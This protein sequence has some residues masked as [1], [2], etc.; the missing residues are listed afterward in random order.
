MGLLRTLCTN[1]LYIKNS[2]AKKILDTFDYIGISIDGREEIHDKFRG[3]KGSFKE[4]LK[5]IKLLN[6]FDSKKI[7]IRFTLTKETYSSLEF[8]FELA[9]NLN[10]PKIYI[11]HLVYSGRGFDNLNIDIKKYER[12][13]AVNYI[14]D[15]AFEYYDT[16]RDIEI[17][18]RKYGD[19][20]NSIFK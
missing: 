7:G 6:S 19:G 13:K 18:T 11:S 2:N 8:I 4:S 10:I 14:I 15:K 20:L 17:V 12:L 9:E 3:L 16:K 1:G 5:A